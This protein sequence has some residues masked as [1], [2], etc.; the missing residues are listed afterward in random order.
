L[1]AFR[2]SAHQ[3]LS[4][5]S[6]IAARFLRIASKKEDWASSLF[7]A[8]FTANSKGTTPSLL[9]L[10][11]LQMVAA[12]IFDAKFA[13]SFF[14]VTANSVLKSSLFPAGSSALDQAPTN[15][16]IWGGGATPAQAL[17]M[18]GLILPPKA[19]A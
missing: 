10:A 3:E 17:Y 14:A 9:N 2:V 12:R 16:T 15:Y 8:T 5:L 4:P 11:P 19:A 6:C 1:A 13:N 18:V 7:R